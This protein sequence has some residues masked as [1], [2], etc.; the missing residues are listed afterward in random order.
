MIERLKREAERMGLPDVEL[1]DQ[2]IKS[3]GA[4]LQ[5]TH[6]LKSNNGGRLQAQRVKLRT[7]RV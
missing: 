5:N 7:G 4:R 6:V 3:K 1:T 2:Y